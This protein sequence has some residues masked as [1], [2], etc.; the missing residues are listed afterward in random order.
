MQADGQNIAAAITAIA[1]DAWVVLIN[2]QHIT[3]RTFQRFQYC[4]P[5]CLHALTVCHVFNN[6]LC[7]GLVVLLQSLHLH[8]CV[9]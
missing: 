2:T 9:K 6:K 3:T 5:A 1:A 8:T 4:V 7:I